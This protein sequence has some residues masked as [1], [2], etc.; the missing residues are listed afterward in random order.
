MSTTIR[1]GTPRWSG[2]SLVVILALSG[3]AAGWDGTATAQQP[4]KDAR[5]A[6]PLSGTIDLRPRFELGREY[7]FDLELQDKEVA[8]PKPGRKPPKPNPS[9]KSPKL[10]HFGQSLGISMKVE[11]VATDGTATL[12]I[13]LDSLKM[14]GDGPMGKIDFDSTKPPNA[15]DP[16][17]SLFRSITT[18]GLKATVSRDGEV[19]EISSD[20]GGSG[21]GSLIAGNVTGGDF[22]RT[23]VGPIFSPRPGKA[24]AHVGESWTE[25][26]QMRASAGDWTILTTKTIT[27]YS[28]GKATIDIRGQVK[29]EPGS[30]GGGGGAGANAKSQ[31]VQEGK[32]VWNT[33][34]GMIDRLDMKMHSEV[35]LLGWVGSLGS[36]GDLSGGAG[37]IDS[38]T[39]AES[40]PTRHE[41]TFKV[42]RQQ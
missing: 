2:R 14:S 31:T 32:A 23:L 33:T 40:K 11:S 26:S 1:F 37:G 8:L 25:E 29:I 22:M 24:T 9:D 41:T 18:T 35:G 17:D 42:R 4:R 12:S 20:S 38:D 5:Q 27:G 16:M 36:I 19:K 39:G 28:G 34:A 13:K 15:Q 21:I 6:E 10:S 7:R 3:L 30:L